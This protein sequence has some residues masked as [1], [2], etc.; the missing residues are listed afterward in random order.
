MTRIRAWPGRECPPSERSGSDGAPSFPTRFSSSDTRPGGIR[1]R[2]MPPVTSTATDGRRDYLERSHGHLRLHP[3]RHC[4]DRRCTDGGSDWCR[5]SVRE[6]RLM[7]KENLSRPA[8]PP[9]GDVGSAW[10][11]FRDLRGE[12]QPQRRSRHDPSGAE[13]RVRPPGSHGTLAIRRKRSVKSSVRRY[14]QAHVRL[15]LQ[16]RRRIG[17]QRV[18]SHG[19]AAGAIAHPR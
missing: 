16:A 15:F 2:P 13:H 14:T 18:R 12:S 8:V 1:P 11:Q 9:G 7:P 17:G 19:A 4:L 6:G 3:G 5:K 10:C